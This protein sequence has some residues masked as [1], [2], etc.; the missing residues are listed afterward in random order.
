MRWG[1]KRGIFWQIFG[2]TLTAILLTRTEVFASSDPVYHQLTVVLNP[3]RHWLSGAD[4]IVLPRESRT[5]TRFRLNSRLDVKKL[6]VEGVDMTKK[7]LKLNSDKRYVEYQVPLLPKA[8]KEDLLALEVVYEGEI[9]DPVKTDKELAFVIGD[10]TTGLIGEEGIF[11]TGE[12]GWYPRFDYSLE[13]YRLRARVPS[14]WVIVS[15]GQEVKQS[16]SGKNLEYVFSSDIPAD[17]LTLVGGKYKVHSRMAGSVAVSTYF[18]EEEESLSDL[19]LNKTAEYLEKFSRILTPYPYKKFDIVENFFTTG[20]GFPSFTLLGRDVIRMGERA[21]RPGYLDHEIVHCWFGNYVYFPPGE[22]NWVEGLTT[23]IANYYTQELESPE[24]AREYRK[25]ISL[26]YSLRVPEKKDYPVRKFEGKEED[27]ENDIGYGK[28]SMIFHLLRDMTGDEEFF[29]ALREFIGRYGGK[30]ATWEEIKKVFEESMRGE[31]PWF[32]HQWLD[33][34]GLPQLQ[35]QDVQLKKIGSEEERQSPHRGYLVQGKIVQVG[36][37]YI[38]PVTLRVQFTGEYQDF[39][40]WVDKQEVPF[41]YFIRSRPVKVELDPDFVIPRKI[42]GSEIPP[43]LNFT[44]ESEPLKIVLPSKMSEKARTQYQAIAERAHQ[45]KGGVISQ[46][47]EISEEELGD[48]SFLVLGSP[49]ENAFLQKILQKYADERV[50]LEERGF[51]IQGKSHSDAGD[52]VLISFR[53]P[54]GSQHSITVYYG[55]SDEA[56][57]KARLIFYYGWESWVVFQNGTPAERGT[58]EVLSPT[59]DFAFSFQPSQEISGENLEKTLNSLTAPEMEGRMAG[60]PGAEI[61]ASFIQNFLTESQPFQ[62]TVKDL[63]PDSLFKIGRKGSLQSILFYPFYFS[64]ETG[65]SPLGFSR[66]FYAGYGSDTKDFNKDAEGALVLIEDGFPP[67]SVTSM[68]DS[69]KALFS[70]IRRA[71]EQGAQGVLL[72]LPDTSYTFPSSMISFPSRLSP[73]D[74]NKRRE[75]ERAGEGKDLRLK[76]VSEHSRM[77]AVDFPLQIPVFAAEKKRILPVLPAL[78]KGVLKNRVAELKIHFTQESIPCK[79]LLAI[80]PGSDPEKANEFIVIG[81]H[82]DHLGM[83]NRKEPYPGAVDNASGIAALLELYRLFVE[84]P[85]KPKKSLVFVAFDGEEWGLQGSSYFTEN[86]PDLS[87]VALMLNIDSI[88]GTAEKSVYLIGQSYF[89]DVAYAIKEKASQMGFEIKEDI[90][91]Y[92][93]RFGSDFYPFYLK[94]IPAV[95]FFDANYRSIH[96]VTDT[97]ARVSLEKLKPLVLFFYEIIYDFANDPLKQ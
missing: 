29:Y 59:T 88:A 86:F 58:W 26:K 97:I 46:D 37:P 19:F 72:L 68:E 82:Y 70:K 24:K 38:L 7:I 10:R 77:P 89:P 28:A 87:K 45:F 53:N 73:P 50:K 36:E 34:T 75:E 42:P 60:S 33:R 74:E 51:Q 5:S 1:E 57:G 90:D 55:L 56:I 67:G 65:D 78:V 8:L 20:Y 61:A 15:Q 76:V 11:L 80:L 84:N 13:I 14:P 25:G 41:Q 17:S 81:A 62:I 69:P 4:K 40:L 31:I 22:G 35:L 27:Y 79:N 49:S 91:R 43:S 21:L 93:Y 30:Y 63:A 52:S 83:N 95:G 16:R 64:P 3:S 23:Y 2:F 66:L 96:K 92:A 44:L 6:L 94:T 85:V 48:F 32:F 12:T 54:S 18:F 71:Q 47:S 9:Y 39:S